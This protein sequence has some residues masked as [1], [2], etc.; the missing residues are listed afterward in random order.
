MDADPPDGW[1]PAA[2]PPGPEDV[3]AA[4]VALGT[5]A[6]VGLVAIDT[7]TGG[8]V[9]LI[10]A[11]PGGTDD[12]APFVPRTPEGTAP[13]VVHADGTVA[14]SRCGRASPYASMAL[15]EHG[16]FCASCGPSQPTQGDGHW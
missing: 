1:E 3:S 6:V 7:L 5:V 9:S 13:P 10:G 8:L 15:N 2:P 11:I 14:C 16:Y 12:P 4:T